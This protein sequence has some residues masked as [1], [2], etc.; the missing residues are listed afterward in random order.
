M[1]P[2][3][4]RTTPDIG[5]GE[6]RQNQ[7]GGDIGGPIIKNKM[8]YFGDYE[9]YRRVQGTRRERRRSNDLER[10]SGFTNLHRFFASTTGTTR[11]DALGRAVQK[12]T[13]LDPGTTRFVANGAVDPVSGLTNTQRQRLLM[14]AIRSARCA[15][16]ARRA[17]RQRAAADLNMI[18]AARIDPN[19]V[20]VLKLYPAPNSGTQVFGSSPA[21]YEHRESV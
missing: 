14:C 1:R 13:I 2:T 4:L 21:L 16:R 7:F 12:G 20:K 3:S 6:L 10:S 8:F 9:G 18:P 5:K 17:S 19:A 15:V 11:T